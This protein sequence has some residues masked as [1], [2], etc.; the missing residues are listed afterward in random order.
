MCTLWAR[1]IPIYC[2]VAGEYQLLKKYNTLLQSMYITL[3]YMVLWND[4][5]G[6]ICVQDSTTLAVGF[7]R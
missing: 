2:I 7:K 3:F 5:I 1:D 4:T 6:M